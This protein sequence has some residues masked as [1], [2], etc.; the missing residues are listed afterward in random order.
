M[1]LRGYADVFERQAFAAA[2][3]T[4]GADERDWLY[5]ARRR[6]KQTAVFLHELGHNLGVSHERD[7]E[8]IMNATY[9]NNSASFSDEARAIMLR[10]LEQRLGG[11]SDASAKMAT[12]TADDHPTLVL[13]VAVTGEASLGGKVLDG[14]ALDE[15]FHVAAA[16][17]RDTEIVVRIAP[18]A[19]TAAVVKVLDRAKAAGLTR[20]SVSA[21]APP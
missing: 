5:E 17:D 14:P 19:P 15:L 18:H 10:T 7:P 16:S 4:L 11:R 6:H 9:S 21:G 8:T 3:P 20:T 1:M 13:T 12:V 2:F